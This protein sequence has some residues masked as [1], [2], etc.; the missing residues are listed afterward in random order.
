MPRISKVRLGDIQYGWMF[1]IQTTEE[2]LDY[3]NH[4]IPVQS[5]AEFKQATEYMAGQAHA[6]VLATLA[7]IKN[8]S[9]IDALTKLNSDRMDGMTQVLNKQHRLFVNRGGGYF[10]FTEGVHAKDTTTC[11]DYILPFEVPRFI[12]WPN[13]THWYAKLGVNDII[14]DGRQKWNTK[15]EAEAAAKRFMV[16]WRAN[17]ESY[18]RTVARLNPK[19]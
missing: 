10:G 5:R 4:V 1:D 16:A 15:E 19:G 12:Q 14:V 8:I 13:G 3:F 9:I 11:S 17:G 7:E 6:N 18:T 2:L